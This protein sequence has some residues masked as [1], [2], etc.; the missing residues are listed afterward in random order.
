MDD[1]NV[2]EGTEAEN[3]PISF[4]LPL[5]LKQTGPEPDMGQGWYPTPYPFPIYNFSGLC[6]PAGRQ[7]MQE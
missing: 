5:S 7:G 2:A 3:E 4:P 1:S 6:L